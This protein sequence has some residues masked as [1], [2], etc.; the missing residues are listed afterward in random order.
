MSQSDSLPY[1]GHI[2]IISAANDHLISPMISASSR[3]SVLL[4]L[5]SHAFPLRFAVAFHFRQLGD[6]RLAGYTRNRRSVRVEKWEKTI[7][8]KPYG[9]GI[10][11]DKIWCKKTS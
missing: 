4:D 6:G 3:P 2:F 7:Y 1:H 11:P 8:D 10:K 5:G 9:E